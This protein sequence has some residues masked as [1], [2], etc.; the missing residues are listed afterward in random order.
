VFEGVTGPDL[1]IEGP[2][3]VTAF[4][5]ATGTGQSRH[6]VTMQHL[7]TARQAARLCADREAQLLGCRWSDTEHQSHAVT[8]IF[9]TGA[10]LEA[11]V[12]EVILDVIDGVVDASP[13]GPPWR[14]SGPSWRGTTPP[15]VVPAFRKLWRQERGLG[16]LSKYQ[17]ALQAVGKPTYDERR[18]PAKSVKLLVELR[19]HFVHYKPEWHDDDAEHHFER[20]LKQANVVE[21]QQ[22]IDMP[23]WFPD[24]ALGAGLAKWTCDISM[25]FANSW[26]K[27]MGLASSHDATFD[28]LPTR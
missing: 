25:R 12:N 19:N 4:T 7:W 13:S 14:E 15:N 24:R 6:Y 22:P 23:P 16:V 2:L 17:K 8:A 27:R 11:L 26:W 18:N 9:F 20:A 21:N 5:F 1:I 10:F 3:K 28:K